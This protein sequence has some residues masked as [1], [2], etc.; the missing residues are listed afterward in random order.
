MSPYLYALFIGLIIGGCIVLLFEI[1][2][3][4]GVISNSELSNIFV[5]RLLVP[6]SAI[7]I[8]NLILALLLTLIIVHSSTYY[9]EILSY[10]ITQVKYYED[11]D[12]EV[13]Y[14]VEHY[15]KDGKLEWVEHKTRI[16]YHPE[17][18]EAIVEGG[19]E[20]S[21]EEEQYYKYKKLWGNNKFEE[22]G[23]DYHNNDGDLYYSD[24]NQNYMTI[25]PYS[26]IK[27][28]ENKIRNSASVFNVW[29]E[30]SDS[31]KKLYPRPA[32]KSNISPILNYSNFTTRP[33]DIE[34]LQRL[35]A[36]FGV[37]SEVHSILVLF[38][39]TANVQKADEMI[40]AWEGTNKNE[41]VTC[42]GLM[43][44][45]AIN[46]VR[47]YS[48]MDNTFIH[49]W[50]R[51]QITSWDKFSVEKYDRLLFQSIPE[52][53]KRKSFAEFDY[54]NFGLS[55]TQFLLIILIPF[56]LSCAVLFFVFIH[57]QP[58]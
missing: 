6:H 1:L 36:Y 41:L 28:Y 56:V 30:V 2:L 24:W 32:D 29:E 52:M 53:W 35:N 17:Y 47:V 31:V 16:D 38:G 43:P 33:N 9:N 19:S 4:K 13:H 20:V 22:L 25:Y 7:L 10:K 55:G 44:D 40:N 27:S 51:Q 50:L 42:V 58:K 37:K 34:L 21:I 15:D 23:R 48:W 26:V 18:Y 5:E 8:G 54:I 12:E 39:G 11:W 45:G 49:S 14:T 46:W 3:K 57:S